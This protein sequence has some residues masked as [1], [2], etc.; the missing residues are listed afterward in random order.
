M[1]LPLRKAVPVILLSCALL[2]GC[3]SDPPPM[4]TEGRYIR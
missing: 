4:V 1:S 3:A 2:S